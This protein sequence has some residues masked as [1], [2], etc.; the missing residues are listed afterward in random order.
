VGSDPRTGLAQLLAVDLESGRR[1]VLTNAG[2]AAPR[3]DGRPPAGF[4]PPPV[5][6][7]PM[8]H[9]EGRLRYDAGDA[10]VALPVTLF[11]ATGDAKAGEATVVPRGGSR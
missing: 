10:F 4:V 2:L 1:S 7:V 6:P 3:G 8:R 11:L 5:G 9:V